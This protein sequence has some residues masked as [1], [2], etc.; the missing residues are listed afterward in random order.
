MS[1]TTVAQGAILLGC[2][3]FAII[4]LTSWTRIASP[5][6][7]FHSS[8][9]SDSVI[10]ITATNIGLGTGVAYLF[11]LSHTHG[12]YALSAP[13][14]VLIGYLLL[15]ALVD[16]ARFPDNIDRNFIYHMDQR[17]KTVHQHPSTFRIIVTPILAITFLLLVAYEIFASSKFFAAI[18]GFA[19]VRMVELGL[20]YFLFIV[21]LLY[22]AVGGIRA[23]IRTDKFQLCLII[24]MIPALLIAGFRYTQSEPQV[25]GALL[26]SYAQLFPHSLNEILTL[27]LVMAFILAISTQ[28]YSIVNWGFSASIEAKKEKKRLFRLSGA[29]TFVL[30]AGIV[31]VGID[32]PRQS[33]A[34]PV[35]DLFRL[36]SDV[37]L[38]DDVMA[39]ILAFVL[40]IGLLGVIL[41]TLDTAIIM[42][43]KFWYDNIEDRDSF[44]KEEVP[45]ELTR[46]R[47]TAVVSMGL[48]FFF[49]SGVNILDPYLFNAALVIASA[50]VVFVPLFLVIFF[51]LPDDASLRR[52]TN[53]VIAVYALMVTA[54]F[55]ASAGLLI[56]EQY[57]YISLVTTLG[58]ISSVAYATYLYYS[59]KVA[60]ARENDRWKIP[61]RL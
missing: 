21:A 8:K 54:T 4:A 58:A 1:P 12:L 17:L 18:L 32:V 55:L 61:S 36:L 15:G 33:A 22:T 23:V 9:V 57:Q 48:V 30:L 53:T 38:A 60:S 11:A 26:P 46:I 28:F 29:F 56:A 20:G 51:L 34:H 10:S 52:I 42:V 6:D 5:N 47:K 16:K 3:T 45:L 27:D 50:V 24:F 41:S 7:F 39:Y 40:T 37:A 59:A 2:V 49:L 44:S 43:R 31:A 14:A 19:N 13:L 35:D 25:G